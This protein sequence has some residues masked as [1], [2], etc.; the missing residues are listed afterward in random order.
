LAHNREGEVRSIFIFSIFGPP[1]PGE[2]KEPAAELL[3]K[4]L[5]GI[6]RG[7]TESESLIGIEKEA[8]QVRGGSVV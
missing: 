3:Q 5:C 7:N 8:D 6:V 2:R 1:A 4:Y